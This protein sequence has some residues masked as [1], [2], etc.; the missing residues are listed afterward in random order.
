MTIEER[1]DWARKAGAGIAVRIEIEYETG[2]VRS[3]TGD[4]AFLI[5][6]YWRG[7]EAHQAIHGGNYTGPTLKITRSAN[8]GPP[9]PANESR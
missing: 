6:Q 3:A 1:K 9:Q 5:L 7:C 2:E 8:D 4:D